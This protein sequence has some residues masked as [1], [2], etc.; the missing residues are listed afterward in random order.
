MLFCV[1]MVRRVSPNCVSETPNNSNSSW[2]NW[3]ASQFAMAVMDAVSSQAFIISP[4]VFILCRGK[5][6]GKSVGR[7]RDSASAPLIYGIRFIIIMSARWSYTNILCRKQD[8]KLALLKGKGNV[9]RDF[10][11]ILLACEI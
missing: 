1:A 9:A 2:L 8:Y 4:S 7:N 10:F 11:L 3:Q 6:N 5:N